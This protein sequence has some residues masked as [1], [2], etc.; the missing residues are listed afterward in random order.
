MK[1]YGSAK[2]AVKYEHTS[3][4][5]ERLRIAATMLD[6]PS[7][8]P[9]VVSGPHAHDNYEK[10]MSAESIDPVTSTNIYVY[11]YICIYAI[12]M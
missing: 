12:G 3:C 4:D 10:L 11:I 2:L 8:A 7:A 6:K 5:K 1:V 9:V